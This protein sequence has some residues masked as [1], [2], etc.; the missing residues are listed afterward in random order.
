M[1]S[2]DRELSPFEDRTPA[3]GKFV[4][5]PSE[6]SDIF[7]EDKNKANNTT[8]ASSNLNFTIN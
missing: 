1:P 4:C 5:M 3:G 6:F 7:E 8:L 2:R